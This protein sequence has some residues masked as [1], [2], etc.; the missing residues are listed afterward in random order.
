MSHILTLHSYTLTEFHNLE[1]LDNKDFLTNKLRANFDF[2]PTL[3]SFLRNSYSTYASHE[4]SD[5]YFTLT[6]SDFKNIVVY[7]SD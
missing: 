2:H 3:S 4:N 1:S 6:I 7:R 5:S